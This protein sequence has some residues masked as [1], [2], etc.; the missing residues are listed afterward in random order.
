MRAIVFITALK[1]I[2]PSGVQMLGVNQD[3]ILF[4][5]TISNES[6]NWLIEN[7]KK[8]YS[9]NKQRIAY[10]DILGDDNKKDISKMQLINISENDYMKLIEI[11]KLALEHPELLPNDGKIPLDLFKTIQWIIDEG[12]SKRADFKDQIA[13]RENKIVENLNAE[14]ILQQ[15]QNGELILDVYGKCGLAICIW[16]MG[17]QLKGMN[18]YVILV[19][20]N[21]SLQLNNIE[22]GSVPI[23]RAS[24][25]FKYLFG[26]DVWIELQT[27]RPKTSFKEM[28]SI[29]TNVINPTQIPFS[30]IIPNRDDPYFCLC[31]ERLND[32]LRVGLMFPEGPRMAR[33][34]MDENSARNIAQPIAKISKSF[35]DASP[36]KTPAVYNPW[37]TYTQQQQPKILEFLRI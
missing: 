1:P 17:I 32:Y 37:K 21:G 33:L 36:Q 34:K 23:K 2:P 5:A 11:S 18:T 15:E 27:D 24:E 26:A 6:Y 14:Q 13:D 28:F 9:E 20:K 7:A 4:T 29:I 35:L 8:Q 3:A 16:R 10:L 22:L 30:A 19:Y 12:L 31:L 25:A